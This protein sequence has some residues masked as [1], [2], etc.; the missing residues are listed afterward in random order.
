MNKQA[1]LK[2]SRVVLVLAGILDLIRGY[3]HTFNIRYAAEY[4]AGIEPIPDS[5][6]LMGAFGISNFLT[7]FI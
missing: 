1:A 6:V 7:A 5:L 2:V 3:A 4:V